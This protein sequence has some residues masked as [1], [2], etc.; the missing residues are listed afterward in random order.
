MKVWRSVQRSSSPA[1]STTKESRSTSWHTTP[2]SSTPAAIDVGRSYDPHTPHK[3]YTTAP[4]VPTR[5]QNIPSWRS[6]LPIARPTCRLRRT[7]RPTTRVGD[8][9]TYR[10]DAPSLRSQ[11]QEQV[12]QSAEAHCPGSAAAGQCRQE[13]GGC[14]CRRVLNF[15]SASE[16]PRKGQL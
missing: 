1:C 15:A 14:E 7:R 2:S 9:V 10:V 3:R 16:P 12:E 4:G 5:H 6:D 11:E 13:Q 8:L